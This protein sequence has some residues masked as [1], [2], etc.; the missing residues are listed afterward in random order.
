M[1]KR[2]Y[3]TIDYGLMISQGFV[4]FPTITGCADYPLPHG[5]FFASD[6]FLPFPG[7]VH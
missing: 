5:V 4:S 6:Y 3:V 2:P 7:D 1:T